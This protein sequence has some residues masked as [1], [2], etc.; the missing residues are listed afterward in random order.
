MK[1]GL[2]LATIESA[3]MVQGWPSIAGADQGDDGAGF[4]GE[5][6]ACRKLVI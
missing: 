6:A 2:A 1:L 3:W 5:Q 4:G